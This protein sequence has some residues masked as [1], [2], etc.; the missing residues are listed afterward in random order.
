[1]T[2]DQG[3]YAGIAAI[4]DRKKVAEN[5]YARALTYGPNARAFLELGLIR[6]KERDFAGSVRILSKGA[7][8]FPDDEQIYLCLGISL[9]NTGAFKQTL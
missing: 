7:G 8:Y 3:D 4:P 6:Q 9:M 5:L 1:M 2:F